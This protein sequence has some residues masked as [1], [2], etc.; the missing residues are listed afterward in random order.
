MNRL[1]AK[2]FLEQMGLRTTLASDGQEAIDAVEAEDF[3]AVLMDI[4]LPGMD[5]LEATR[6][7]RA[8]GEPSKR[9]VPIIAMSAH[10]FTSEID[11][12]LRAGMD[13]FIGKPISPER[14]GEIL[15][16]V[17]LGA[18]GT[19]S[20]PAEDTSGDDP[21][22]A[23][24]EALA[25]DLETIGA[26][27]TERMVNL[28]LRTAPEHVQ[29][30]RAAIEAGDFDGVAFAAHNL[31][32]SAGSLGLTFLADRSSALEAAAKAKNRAELANFRKGLGSIYEQSARLLT[33]TWA[34]LRA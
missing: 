29:Q 16:R 2:T 25:H 9:K 1:V 20:L 23:A 7:I 27:R 17:L 28:F 12:H 34:L 21:A 33:E 5:G 26:E 14:L 24:R 18:G 6:R 30:L 10:V 3:D 13:A 11:E 32:N 31:K 4:S 15:A 22:D 19:R 8:M